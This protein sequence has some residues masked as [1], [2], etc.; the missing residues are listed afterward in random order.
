MEL[1]V[2]IRQM[3]GLQIGPLNPIDIAAHCAGHAGV[4]FLTDYSGVGL[5][6]DVVGALAAGSFSPPL[7]Q[8]AAFLEE[9][10]LILRSE[11]WIA[12]H[13]VRL[14]REQ[15]VRLLGLWDQKSQ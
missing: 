1:H 8:D 12:L 10:L 14:L 7:G 15:Y 11:V 3:Q 5:T 4:S 13:Q 6:Q 2:L 9:T